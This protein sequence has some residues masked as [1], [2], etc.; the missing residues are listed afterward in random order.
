[1][2]KP[3]EYLGYKFSIQPLNRNAKKVKISIAEKK[4]KK[5]KT[6]LILSFVDFLKDSNITILEKRIK[7]L[8]GNFS[9][10]SSS[11][12]G[13]DLKAGIYYNYLFINDL[14]PL[15][16]LNEFYHKVLNSKSGSFGSKLSA[17]LTVGDKTRLKKYSFKHGFES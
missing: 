16:E 1:E 9:I 5:I 4:V 2:K 12:S 15:R 13:H 8:T 17:K 6:R 11:G 10:K 7:F 3:L 14:S